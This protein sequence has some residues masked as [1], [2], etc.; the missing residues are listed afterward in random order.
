MFNHSQ[1]SILKARHKKAEGN[2]KAF[3]SSLDGASPMPDSP[4]IIVSH[5]YLQFKNRNLIIIL[6]YE[7]GLRGHSF[8]PN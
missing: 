1:K 4:K 3:G 2:I 8:L 5:C 6:P 7:G